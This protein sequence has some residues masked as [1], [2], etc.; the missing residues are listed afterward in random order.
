MHKCNIFYYFLLFSSLLIG[1][2]TSNLRNDKNKTIEYRIDKSKSLSQNGE[3]I[4]EKYLFINFNKLYE[5][6]NNLNRQDLAKFNHVHITLCVN[7]EYHLLASVTIA[8]ILNN[9]NSNTYN[10]FH[11][12]ALN[13]LSIKTMEKIFSLRAKINKNSEFI[14]YNGKRAEEDFQVAAKTSPRGM[15]DFGRLLISE[16]T[17]FSFPCVG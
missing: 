1:F 5:M 4:Y 12:I 10:H 16:L 8:S 15:I 9:S 13:N 14:F 2:S 7:E 6:Y 17:Y 11:I 3:R